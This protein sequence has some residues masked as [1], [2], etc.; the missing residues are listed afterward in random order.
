VRWACVA[1]ALLIALPALAVNLL[2][3]EATFGWEQTGEVE[4]EGWVIWVSRNGGDIVNEGTV[5]EKMVT[6]NG[7]PNETLEVTV[8]AF[9]GDTYSEMS[10]P[11]DPVTFRVLSAP[12]G[13]ALHC[14][15]GVREI[16]PGWFSLSDC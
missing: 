13:P 7:A 2:G 9:V 11:S 12:E 8:Q 15:G 14:P 6:V 4:P 5:T 16:S 1:L 3:T 10:V